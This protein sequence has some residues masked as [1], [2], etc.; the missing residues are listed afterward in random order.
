MSTSTEE[1]IPKIEESTEENV[2]KVG[3]M[4]RH[5]GNGQNYIIV[6]VDGR[7][8]HTDPPEIMV[9]Y[10]ANYKDDTYGDKAKWY[11]LLSNWMEIVKVHGQTKPR[12][13]K[14]EDAK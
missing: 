11:R 5:S 4:W 10:R 6:S 2:P 12:F 14:I 8:V 13:I 1:N 9:E 3:E 7:S